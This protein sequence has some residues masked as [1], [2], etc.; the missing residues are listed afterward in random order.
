MVGSDG[1][2]CSVAHQK[3]IDKHKFSAARGCRQRGR[4]AVQRIQKKSLYRRETMGYER[5]TMVI[6][7]SGVIRKVFPKVKVNRH[8][9]EVIAALRDIG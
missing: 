2:K 3:F 7:K 9:A 4:Q 6:D 1:D 8:T 5:A